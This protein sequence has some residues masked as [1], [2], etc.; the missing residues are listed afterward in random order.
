[1]ISFVQVSTLEASGN[2]QDKK[3][4]QHDSIRAPSVFH[5]GGLHK[6]SDV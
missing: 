2:E 6:H 1:M 3:A 4:Q 5:V